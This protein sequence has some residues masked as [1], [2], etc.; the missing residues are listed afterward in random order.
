MR[1][2]GSRTTAFSGARLGVKSTPLVTRGVT[3]ATMM[4]QGIH[5]EWYAEAKVICNGV[6]VMTVGGT[7]QTYNVDIYSG[8]HPFYQGNKTSMVVDEGQL[9]RYGINVSRAQVKRC[10]EILSYGSLNTLPTGSRSASLTWAWRLVLLP[11]S[12]ARPLM[13]TPPSRRH[14]LA[15]ARAG[16]KLL[17]ASTSKPRDQ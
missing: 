10:V 9:N 12:P 17:R 11:P 5:P 4:K 3:G 1:A 16:S 13:R 14:L 7:K 6:E 2:C 15:R 8:N